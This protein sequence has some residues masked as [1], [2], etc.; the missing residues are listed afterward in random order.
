[1]PAPRKQY[2]WVLGRELYNR[3]L[4]DRKIAAQLSCTKSAVYDWRIREKLEAV[5]HAYASKLLSK[6][7][8]YAWYA[9]AARRFQNNEQLPDIAEA[10]GI[11]VDTLRS[12]ARR[13][14]LQIAPRDFRAKEARGILDHCG[15]IMLRVE[16]SGPYGYLI[17]A[18]S[19]NKE[20]GYA[21]L[22]RMRM[23]DKLGRELLP[24]EVVHHIDGDIYNCSP[25]NLEVFESNGEHLSKTRKGVS[26]SAVGV[27]ASR[28]NAEHA[29]KVRAQYRANRQSDHQ[30]QGPSASANQKVSK[31]D[32][33]P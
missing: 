5:A 13:N 24:G 14:G 6:T 10:L 8:G 21:A 27:E 19:I 25:S 30:A 2:D 29:R 32:D 4:S 11:S 7:Y 3:G 18:S 17:R 9:E 1:M 28:R 33:H 20:K 26:Q 16:V 12:F 23:H 15:Y 22:H 31:S